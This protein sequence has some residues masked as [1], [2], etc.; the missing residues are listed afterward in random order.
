LPGWHSRYLF[1]LSHFA[2]KSEPNFSL[3]LFYSHRWSLNTCGK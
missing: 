2:S 3:I 1:L